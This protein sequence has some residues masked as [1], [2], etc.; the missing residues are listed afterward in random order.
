MHRII[1]W[2][3]FQLGI[4]AQ[5][6]QDFGQIRAYLTGMKRILVCGG[7]VYS[8]RAAVYEL[9]DNLHAEHS[10]SVLIAGGARGADSLA[11]EWACDRGIPTQIYQADWKRH[12]RAAGP[13][14]NEQ[15]LKEGHPDLVVAFPGG[16]GTAGM[17]A[18]ARAAKVPVF[19]WS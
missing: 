1:T 6:P 12:G 16:K 7:R 3:G 15:M 18:L 11:E 13:I 9:L 10:F 2:V 5:S 8:D 19:L 17:I 4:M 14:R